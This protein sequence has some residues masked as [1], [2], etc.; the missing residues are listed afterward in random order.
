MK[1]ESWCE[2]KALADL[3]V[4]FIGQDG[5]HRVQ[6]IDKQLNLILLRRQKQSTNVRLVISIKT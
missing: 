1:H 5:F 2:A 3:H 4:I 6:S